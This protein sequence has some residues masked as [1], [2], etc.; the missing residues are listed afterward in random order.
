MRIIKAAIFISNNRPVLYLYN[1]SGAR[2]ASM[3]QLS[4]CQDT[5]HHRFSNRN[6]ANANAGVVSAFGAYADFFTIA[7]DGFDLG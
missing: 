5:G 2:L 4:I 7:R 3:A 6:S 1:K